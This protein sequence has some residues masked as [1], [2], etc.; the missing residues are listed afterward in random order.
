MIRETPFVH[1]TLRVTQETMDYFQK[2]PS[3]SKEMRDVLHSY[4]TAATKK[5]QD[6]AGT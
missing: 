3:P 6:N 1:F 4:V 5:D 2:F